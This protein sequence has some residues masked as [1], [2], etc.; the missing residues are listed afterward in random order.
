M[1]IL[2]SN[3]DGVNAIGLKVLADALSS[4]GEVTVIAPDR[5]RSGS[6]NSLT[7]ENPVRISKLENG[8][9]AV[10][11]TPTD[12][13][14]LGITAW[15]KNRPDLVVSGINS[16]PNLGDD[17]FYSGTVAAAIE[18][19]FFDIPAIA[20][21][22]GA[23]YPEK[24]QYEVAG[25]VAQEL[26]KQVSL[27]SFLKPVL[28]NVNVPDLEFEAIKGYQVVRLGNRHR[29]ER[30]IQSEDPR[31][32]EVYWIGAAGPEQDAGP[33]TDFHA[34]K[35]GYVTITPLQT[36]LTGYSLMDNLNQ[37]INT[38]KKVT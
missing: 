33:G 10:T 25:R 29:A 16:G 34:I 12:C 15:M 3:D 28:I 8:F 27:E 9:F 17:V 2:V 26:V 18:A 5:D 31:G 4:L 30:T 32:H 20:I 24:H 19:R 6:S 7:I 22:M 1:R 21:S 37:W 23:R 35:S 11:G 36:D 14:H 13:V 38:K